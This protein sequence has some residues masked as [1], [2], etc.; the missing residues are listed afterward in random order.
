MPGF[1][2]YDDI[3]N[4][5]TTNNQT[6]DRQ[7]YK[8]GP[9]LQGAGTWSRLFLAAGIPAAG[10]EP[11]ATPGAA[12][13]ANT[14][15]WTFG[16][17]SPK[18]RYG[19]SFGGVA[20]QNTTLMLYDR[21]VGVGG[22]SIA[23]TGAKTVNSAAL[24]RYTTGAGVQCWLEVST[25][26]TTTAAVVNLNQY[27]GDVNG[28]A[29]TGGNITFPA[30]ATVAQAAIGPLPIAAGDTGV[31][32]VQ[33]GLNVVTATTAGVVSVVLLRPLAF[34][35]IIANQWNERDLVLQLASL[36]QVFD[37]ACLSLYMLATAATATNVW[38]SLKTG[39]A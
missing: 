21:L 36:P 29:Q 2:S 32:S 39:Y 19:L 18:E 25:A 28:A 5:T 24:T 9:A 15:C 6:D 35:P 31:K 4:Q 17:V 23:A 8:T 10:T 26:T 16:N 7:L 33:V 1:T 27:T 20:T 11:A 22:I 34:L 38:A 12:Y 30:A 37:T 13:S 3:I 14:S